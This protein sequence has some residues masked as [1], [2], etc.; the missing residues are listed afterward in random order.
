MDVSEVICSLNQTQ[1]NTGYCVLQYIEV[2][3]P[4]KKLHSFYNVI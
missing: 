3:F 1:K 4:G 2:E